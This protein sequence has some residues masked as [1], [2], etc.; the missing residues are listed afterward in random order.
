MKPD[1]LSAGSDH[2]DEHA[3]LHAGAL[4][5]W[6]N[7]GGSLGPADH[8]RRGHKRGGAS[9]RSRKHTRLSGSLLNRS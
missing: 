1:F 7:E 6:E 3:A 9:V 8:I 2:L 4:D 5:V